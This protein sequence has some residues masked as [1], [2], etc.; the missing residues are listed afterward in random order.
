MRSHDL[1]QFNVAEPVAPVDSPALVDFANA[2]DRIN[3]LA[4]QAPGFVWRCVEDAREAQG[5]RPFG[6]N[7]IATLSTWESMELLSAFVY[8]SDHV[9]YLRRRKEWF[10]PMSSANMVLWWVPH[11]HQPEFSEAVERLEHLRINGPSAYAFTFADRFAAPQP[12]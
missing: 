7:I 5:A 10:K 8:R 1:A 2:L 4:E 12:A 11:Q 6:N 3:A 9:A